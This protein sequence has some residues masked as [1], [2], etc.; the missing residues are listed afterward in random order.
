MPDLTIEQALAEAAPTGRPA[1]GY[2]AVVARSPGFAEE[3]DAEFLRLC[4]AFGQPPPGE[5]LPTCVFARPLARDVVAVVQAAAEG[6][7]PRLQFHCLALPAGL[8]AA[9][10]DPFLVAEQ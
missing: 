10:G 8:Y 3:W 6:T 9:V 7:P 4:A 2:P 1:S 5:Y